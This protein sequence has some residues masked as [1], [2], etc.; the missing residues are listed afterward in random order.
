ML[1]YLHSSRNA[2]GFVHL[3]QSEELSFSYN[4]ISRNC[5]QISLRESGAT[6]Y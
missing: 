1:I 5:K 3:R 2:I 4:L 6:R